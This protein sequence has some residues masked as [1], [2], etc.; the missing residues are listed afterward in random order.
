MA[1]THELLHGLP[2]VANYLGD[3]PRRL[4]RAE[5]AGTGEVGYEFLRRRYCARHPSRMADFYAERQDS[6]PL[7]G[8]NSAFIRLAY[9][10][11][12]HSLPGRGHARLCPGGAPGMGH[13]QRH[14]PPKPPAA[15]TAL[16][17]PG[18]R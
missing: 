8:R 5:R 15:I 14:S 1:P 9:A 18:R 7:S 4:A 16:H 17:E 13:Q 11:P 10:E 2:E 6:C 3:D 12:G